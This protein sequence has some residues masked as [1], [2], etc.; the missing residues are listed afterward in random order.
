M[1]NKFLQTVFSELLMV[2]VTV[3]FS[4]GYTPPPALKKIFDT[5][6]FES[7]VVFAVL[8]SALGQDAVRAGVWAAFTYLVDHYFRNILPAQKAK[9]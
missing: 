1:N 9:K 3:S 5:P 4:A 6:E 8:Y 2:I 7:F